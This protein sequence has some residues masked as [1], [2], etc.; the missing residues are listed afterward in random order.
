MA[1]LLNRGLKYIPTPT[2]S[3]NERNPLL[4]YFEEFTK[5]IRLQYFYAHSPTNQPLLKQPFKTKSQW[6]PP[7]GPN[8]LER[9][10]TLTKKVLLKHDC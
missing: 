8:N 10:I 3:G 1:Q 2:M 5:S 6:E 9:Y 4:E 7:K